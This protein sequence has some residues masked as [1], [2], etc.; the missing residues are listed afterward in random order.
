MDNPEERLPPAIGVGRRKFLFRAAAAGTVAFVVP[1]IVTI[2]TAGAADLTSPPPEPP[3]EPAVVEGEVVTND[4]GDPG[5]PGGTGGTG[6]GGSSPQGAQVAGATTTRGELAETGVEA[7]D[8]LVAG[9]AATAGGAALLL[10]SADAAG[11]SSAMA[12]LVEQTAP[13][14]RPSADSPGR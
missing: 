13:R 5:D 11:S 10:W 3:D 8:L 12:R 1:T 14:A 2:E 6:T 4:P 9:L 7:D